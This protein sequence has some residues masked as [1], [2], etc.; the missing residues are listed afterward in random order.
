MVGLLGVLWWQLP[1]ALSW[2]LTQF[3]QQQGLTNITVKIRDVRASEIFIKQLDVS[4]DEP[5]TELRMQLEHIRLEYSL[6]ELINGQAHS[7]F[8]SSVA[9]KLDHQPNPQ[10]STSPT[11][12]NIEQL[13]AAFKAVDPAAFPVNTVH[14]PDI[15][16]SH[17]LASDTA[18]RFD[19]IKLQADLSKSENKLTTKLVF[20]N[21][22]ALHWTSD[23]KRGWNVHFFDAPDQQQE[24]QARDTVFN[25]GL[26]QVNQSLV[27][28]AG[29]KP[30]L[31]KHMPLFNTLADNSIG[32]AQVT[33]SGT[34][35]AAESVP[36][37]AISSS[38]QVSDLAYQNASIQTL[39]GQFDLQVAQASLERHQT[40]WKLG[41]KFNN[42]VSLINAS[43]VDWQ[44]DKIT[45]SAS[46]DLNL[47][48]GVS[49]ITSS[50]VLVSIGKLQLAKELKLNETAFSGAAS[51]TMN[52][53]QWQLEL[54]NAWQLTSQY[55]RMGET[56]LPQGLSV[57]SSEPTHVIGAFD[58][59]SQT[60]AQ[61]GSAADSV[62]FDKTSLTIKLPVA[63]SINALQSV[64][65]VD[66][67]LQINQARLDQGQLSAS[68][69]LVIPELTMV[70]NS[71]VAPT[72]SSTNTNQTPTKNFDS[73]GFSLS[74]ANFKQSFEFANDVLTSRGSVDSIERN[75]HI[76][77]SGK[78]DL[79][80]EQ[81]EA[82]FHFKTIEFNDTQR[83]NQLTSPLI[84]P[85]N[86]VTGTAKLSGK[87]RW[88]RKRDEWHAT[89]NVDT[90]LI[91]LGGAYDET[92]FSGV[93]AK[94]SLQ[95]YPDILSKKPQHLNIAFVDTGV[96]STDLAVEFTLR[97][98]TLG[99]LPVV[100]LL[101]AKTQLLQGTMSLEPGTYDLNR[102]QQKLQV[103]MEN[104]NLSELVRLQQLDDIQAT[105]LVTGQLPI[106]VNNG[107]VSI[108]NGQLQAIA[109]GG[110]LRYQA[111]ADALKANK[112]AETVV[113]ALSN[114]N[115]EALRADTHYD[116]NG[117]LLLKLQLQGHNPDFEQ[118]R[119]VNLN[120]N[121]EQNVLKLFESVRLIDGVS[122]A[123]DKRV[124]DFYQRT[125]SQ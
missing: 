48:E 113:K 84:V 80:K 61:L 22:Q 73:N 88:A 50:D 97:P 5:G 42:S 16:F 85:V 117:T 105:G 81:G 38:V 106:V 58:M 34:I 40:P 95:V 14:L 60:N 90:Q 79:K 46:G 53:K 51:L 21:N 74:L 2:G 68:G 65:G 44:A 120:I 109:P 25:A 89:V 54:A 4:Y 56:E 87:T 39:D 52:A 71:T 91:N 76:T 26:K 12:P 64:R 112:Y 116:P 59:A 19:V 93:N 101:H 18:P 3:L 41:I 29:V 98:S 57:H 9:L 32:L 15:S 77:S 111:D 43:F 28:S 108:D 27:F 119:Q 78:H 49:K 11:L 67:T 31:A 94:S 63:Q 69:S 70:D 66:A 20:A 8:I 118:G 107:E 103:A 72:T 17:N 1:A 47:T 6:S 100:N 37:L 115:Y 96:V 86:I 10:L 104:I 82:D 99:D 114:F 45:L 35:K 125:T 124:N 102:A 33:V 83:L 55:A 23:A 123:L 13:L 36:G 122:D 121:L 24:A 62:L 75:L 7:L 110:I 30:S 92:Y